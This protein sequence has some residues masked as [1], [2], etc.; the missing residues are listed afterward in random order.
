MST[1]PGHYL[2][3]AEGAEEDEVWLDELESELLLELVAELDEELTFL[4]QQQQCSS[5]VQSC[6]TSTPNKGTIS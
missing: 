3:L 4:Q 6:L 2:R 1:Q 5:M